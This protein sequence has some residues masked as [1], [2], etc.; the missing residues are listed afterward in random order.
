[1][2]LGPNNLESFE[3]SD[4]VY[5]AGFIPQG[6]NETQSYNN[7]FL[8]A[9]ITY[10]PDR[11]P[12]GHWLAT[13]LSAH[14]QKKQDKESPLQIRKEVEVIDKKVLYQINFLLYSKWTLMLCFTQW[15]PSHGYSITACR[16]TKTLFGQ[17][18]GKTKTLHKHH[19]WQLW[20]CLVLTKAFWDLF[21]SSFH[22]GTFHLYAATGFFFV[23]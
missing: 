17:A 1:M 14:L 3:F 13:P 12:L 4:A 19:H 11:T 15:I 22:S 9:C 5:W 18:S 21:F 23:A 10:Q 6:W 2:S 7:I 20:H 16:V 8:F